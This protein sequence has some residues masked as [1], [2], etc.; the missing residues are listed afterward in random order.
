MSD[1][2]FAM[3]PHRRTLRRRDRDGRRRRGE[4]RRI[5]TAGLR[6]D[7]RRLRRRRRRLLFGPLPREPGVLLREPGRPLRRLHHGIGLLQRQLRRH[8]VYVLQRRRP[9]LRRVPQLLHGYP[10]GG[11][12]TCCGQTGASCTGPGD[13]C[14]GTICGDGMT[15]EG[16]ENPNTCC[17]PAGGNCATDSDCCFDAPNCFGGTC[18]KSVGTACT[19]GSECCGSECGSDGTCD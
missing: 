3:A 13:C 1:H 4:H 10:C 5:R 12:G 17:A 16:E 7:L 2:A 6:G 19:T 9:A 11:N 18:C 14:N 15:S 8:H